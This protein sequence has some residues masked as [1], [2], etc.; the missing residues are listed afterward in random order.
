MTTTSGPRTGKDL[1]SP[2]QRDI[3]HHT[4]ILRCEELTHKYPSK[5]PERLIPFYF[6]REEQKKI[7][8]YGKVVSNFLII[9]SL[10]PFFFFQKSPSDCL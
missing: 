7:E 5:Y 2:D 10:K 9:K 8:M 1:A 3:P 4:A 6:L